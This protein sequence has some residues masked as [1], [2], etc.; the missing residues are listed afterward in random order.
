MR[1]SDASDVTGSADPFSVLGVP[2]DCT[3]EA[4]Q[5]AYHTLARRYH[6]DVNSDHGA[7]VRMR[8]INSAYHAAQRQLTARAAWQEGRPAAVH[9]AE[10]HVPPPA[11]GEPAPPRAM[12]HQPR[13][14]SAPP[15]VGMIV[16]EPPPA[17]GAD[18]VP[19][20]TSHNGAWPGFPVTCAWPAEPRAWIVR[21]ARPALAGVCLVLVAAGLVWALLPG[22]RVGRHA[23]RVAASPTARSPAVMSGQRTL[24]LGR[25]IVLDWPGAGRVT[26]LEHMVA[27]LPA[28]LRLRESPQWSFDNAFVAV[29]ASGDASDTLA[30]ST[31]FV[32]HARDGHV[33]S[34]LSGGSPRWSPRT[35]QLAFLVQP[36]A[37]RAAL[38]RVVAVAE[39]GVS[40]PETVAAGGDP[41]WSPDG[42]AIVLSTGG[43]R[44]LQLLDIASG[45][46]AP[47]F[48]ALPGQRVVPLLWT[49]PQTLLGAEMTAGDT[50]LVKIRSDAGGLMALADLGPD[51]VI[52]ASAPSAD[53]EGIVLAAR[54]PGQASVMLYVLDRHTWAVTPAGSVPGIKY[55]AGWSADGRWLALAPP[56][57]ASGEGRLCLVPISGGQMPAALSAAMSCVRFDGALAGLAWEA[58]GTRLSYVRVVGPGLGVQLREMAVGP[59]PGQ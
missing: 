34:N 58:A 27:E 48:R 49:D 52:Q 22:A 41:T 26:L 16:E 44:V 33:L 25:G 43:G 19:A 50:R 9:A 55:V 20:E 31:I 35:D 5:H 46:A 6:P 10:E 12:P 4:L 23:A 18:R 39:G 54:S 1:T 21:V 51:R 42:A 53:G 28:G 17:P 8:Q 32:I 45:V 14:R 59:P 36:P 38:L 40:A 29:V 24:A 7:T 37:A 3:P 57:A 47:L 11:A 30:R 56:S 15:Q 2:R 13:T